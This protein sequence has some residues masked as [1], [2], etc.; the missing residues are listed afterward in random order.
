MGTLSYS[1]FIP[2]S[3]AIRQKFSH[4]T[5]E[6]LFFFIFFIFFF[7]NAVTLTIFFSIEFYTYS[8][9]KNVIKIFFFLYH[10]NHRYNRLSVIPSTLANC[11]NMDEFNVEGNN[12]SFLP[13]SFI[14]VFERIHLVVRASGVNIFRPI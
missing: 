1:V 12:I 13:V 6:I 5:H 4:H 2:K 11:V 14:I 3:Y 9:L 10:A 7:L 8:S